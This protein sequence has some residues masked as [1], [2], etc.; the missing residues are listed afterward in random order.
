[1]SASFIPLLNISNLHYLETEDTWGLVRETNKW[2]GSMRFDYRMIFI[3]TYL[4]WS[5]EMLWW[6][7][8]AK[9]RAWPRAVWYSLIFYVFLWETMRQEL[10]ERPDL[11]NWKFFSSSCT[12]VQI[13]F[14]FLFILMHW[15]ASK[16]SKN[17]RFHPTQGPLLVFQLWISPV[18]STN[19]TF[20][21]SLLNSPWFS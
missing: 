12:S 6:K 5:K 1:M 4:T 21:S 11:I 9:C 7:G 3:K 10:W 20:V 8:A 15:S 16:V 17:T 18:A 13:L 2:S 14:S 19:W